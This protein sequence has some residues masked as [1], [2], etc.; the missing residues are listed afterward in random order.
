MEGGGFH[1]H[2]PVAVALV[3]P[4][5]AVGVE[6][7]L[8]QAEPPL[9]V[10]VHGDGHAGGVPVV[11]VFIRDGGAVARAVDKAAGLIGEGIVFGKAVRPQGLIGHQNRV[12]VDVQLRGGEGVLQVILP[13]VL[14]H[15]G[16]LNIGVVPGKAPGQTA[17]GGLVG[18]SLLGPQL[19]GHLHQGLEELLGLGLDVL[20]GLGAHMVRS[21]PLIAPGLVV[22]GEHDLLFPDG[23]HG[24]RIQLHAPD[25]RDVGAAPVKVKSA[26]LIHKEIRVPDGKGSLDLLPLAAEGIF[27]AVEIAG[28][29]ALAGGEIEVISR[30][31]NVR[32]I[33][34]HRDRRFQGVILPV[35]HV[36]RDIKA[37]GH[38]GEKIIAPLEQ[39]QRGVGRLPVNRELWLSQARHVG[40]LKIVFIG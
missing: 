23:Q 12:A 9:H 38:G 17:H 7:G 24:L 31:A 19:R 8:P 11:A 39:L 2:G 21:D 35:H 27:R 33:V 36:V 26:V 14:G 3:A 40:N 10:V 29:I 20:P 22:H 15:I 16:A 34:E 18:E 30:R 6:A 4:E 37:P 32:R 13:A 28:L 5:L 1:V 25:G